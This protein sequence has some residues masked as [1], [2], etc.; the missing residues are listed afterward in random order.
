MESSIAVTASETAGTVF[1]PLRNEC[2]SFTNK[3]NS[4]MNGYHEYKAC[5]EACLK[6]AA[7][8]N[9]CA[10]SCTQ[11]PEIKMM[12]QCIA[13][14]MQCATICYAAAQLMSMGSEQ[15]QA[16]C[17]ICVD[18]CEQCAAECSKH[19]TEHCKECAAA[20]KACAEACHHMLS[21]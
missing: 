21:R 18:I 2:Y 12:A 11:E 14:D 15:A 6:C 17:R 16:I 3:T 1:R 10:A 20:C 7:I 5:I 4:A 8:C 9:H 13:L 19:D